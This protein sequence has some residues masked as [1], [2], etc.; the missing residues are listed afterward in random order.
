MSNKN[1]QSRNIPFIFIYFKAILLFIYK[2]LLNYS[3]TL[4]HIKNFILECQPFE[5][6]I[7]QLFNKCPF[8]AS[9]VEW[10]VCSTLIAMLTVV[11]LRPTEL[12]SAL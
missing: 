4:R 5:M 6:I 10:L 7:V 1:I 12:Q 11:G 9:V 3:T 8:V 2:T